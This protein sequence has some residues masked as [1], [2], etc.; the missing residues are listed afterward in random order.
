M[1]YKF[2][3]FHF[4]YCIPRCLRGDSPLS[5]SLNLPRLRP[6]E[7]SV[8]SQLILVHTFGTVS[9]VLSLQVEVK[10]LEIVL[11]STPAINRYVFFLMVW[12]YGNGMGTIGALLG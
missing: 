9:S 5:L 7:S 8:F 3:L 12:L 11:E 2:H 4:V 1:F 6:M 10:Y